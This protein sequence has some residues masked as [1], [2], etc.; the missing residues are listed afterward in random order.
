MKN[1]I[2]AFVTLLIIS[3]SDNPKQ[4][5][6]EVNVNDNSEL[7]SKVEKQED[8]AQTIINLARKKDS[9]VKILENTKQ[10]ISRM[11][12]EKI[13]KGIEGVNQKLNE[14]K[15]QKENFEE[16]VNL[17]KKEIDLATKKVELLKEEK[18]VYDHRF[19]GINCDLP[20]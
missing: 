4:K 16:Q 14:L 6:E 15:G 1:S 5:N 8:L 10:S 3:C 19:E 17:Q 2:L 18:I 20:W 9:L 12:D 11:N 7:L 13:D